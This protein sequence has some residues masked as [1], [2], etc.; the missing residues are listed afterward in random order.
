MRDAALVLPGS[1]DPILTPAVA[2]V[3][4]VWRRELHSFGEIVDKNITVGTSRKQF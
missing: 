1:L 3:A 2:S 4:F